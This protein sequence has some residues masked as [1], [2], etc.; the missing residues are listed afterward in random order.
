[1]SP[2]QDLDPDALRRRSRRN[3]ALFLLHLVFA[4]ACFL[5]FFLRVVREAAQGG[6][7][8]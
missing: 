2:G 3:I 4:G 5:F 8:G 1:M 6:A 7:A